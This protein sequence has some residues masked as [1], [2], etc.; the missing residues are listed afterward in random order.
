MDLGHCFSIPPH[1]GAFRWIILLQIDAKRCRNTFDGHLL[2]SRTKKNKEEHRR[3]SS[4]DAMAISQIWN[5]HPSSHPLTG[6][7]AIASKNH[8]DTGCGACF[9]RSGDQGTVI[10]IYIDG[11]EHSTFSLDFPQVRDVDNNGDD[12][13]IEVHDVDEKPDDYGSWNF[14]PE[15]L[16]RTGWKCLH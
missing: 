10:C 9:T 15:S 14:Q 7:T 5:Y 12:D 13:K 11:C 1:Q 2:Q 4:V 3:T 8:C 6:V 16:S